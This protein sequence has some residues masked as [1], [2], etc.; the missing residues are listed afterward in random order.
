MRAIDDLRRW[1]MGW[2]TSSVHSTSN[3]DSG[4]GRHDPDP[5]CCGHAWFDWTGISHITA[6]SRSLM[7]AWGLQQSLLSRLLQFDYPFPLLVAADSGIQHRFLPPPP[8]HHSTERSSA[9]N[10]RYGRSGS[11]AVMIAQTH[12]EFSVMIVS[13]PDRGSQRIRH[14]GLVPPMEHQTSGILTKFQRLHLRFWSRVKL[15]KKK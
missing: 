15:R 7:L 2:S 4:N 6:L 9:V 12:R 8:Y 5:L 13:C 10:R 3:W 1:R 14:S 11:V